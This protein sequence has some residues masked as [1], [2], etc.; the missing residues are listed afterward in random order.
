MSDA[1]GHDEPGAPGRDGGGDG[2]EPVEAAVDPAAVK[3]PSDSP[4]QASSWV[5]TALVLVVGMLIG[6]LGLALGTGDAALGVECGVHPAGVDAHIE[7]HLALRRAGWDLVDAF[8]SRWTLEP[9]ELAVWLT[10]E[11]NERRDAAA[12]ETAD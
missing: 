9:E 11:M 4:L 8:Q 3:D 7:R 5:R 2:D 12:R 10:V 6:A 1:R